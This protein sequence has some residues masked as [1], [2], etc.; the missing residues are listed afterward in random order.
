MATV[1]TDYKS[2]IQVHALI[3]LKASG[4]F[5]QIQANRGYYRKLCNCTTLVYPN[6]D[7]YQLELDVLR[8]Y[9]DRQNTKNKEQLQDQLR[10]ILRCFVMR[11][12]KIGYF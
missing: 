6:S 7:F 11:N 12:A 3:W 2:E 10:N 4:A 8:T 9:P 5:N 1:A